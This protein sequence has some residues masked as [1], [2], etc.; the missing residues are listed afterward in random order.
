[1]KLVI[2]TQHKENYA[3]HD[4]DYVHGVSEPYWKL[5]GGSTYIVPS[6]EF[7]SVEVTQNAVDNLEAMFC[8]SNEC[9]E[10]YVLGWSIRED[11]SRVC[12][13]WETPTMVML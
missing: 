6:Y 4:E 3:A 12:E 1:M 10:E 11:S 9:A 13:D 2:Q 7:A 8:F 5:K